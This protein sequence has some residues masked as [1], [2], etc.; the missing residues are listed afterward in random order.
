MF[1]YAYTL[2]YV[3][4]LLT[5]YKEYRPEPLR[6]YFYEHLVPV[7]IFSFK[8]TMCCVLELYFPAASVTCHP[9]LVLSHQT[10]L[11]RHRRVQLSSLQFSHTVVSDS[12]Q[13]HGLQHARPPCSSPTLGACSNSCPLHWWCHPTILPS[14]VSFSSC[15]QSFPGSGS[16]QMSKFFTSGGQSIGIS[17]SASVL[18]MNIQDQFPLGWTGWISLQSKGLSRVFSNTTVQKHQFFGTLLSL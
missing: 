13:A 18:P 7:L 10:F 14:V 17:A 11:D 5:E 1:H 16:F 9:S 2:R 6:S 3:F 8:S 15:F 4:T 12:L